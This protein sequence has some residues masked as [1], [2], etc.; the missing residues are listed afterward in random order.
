MKEMLG[1]K[2]MFPGLWLLPLLVFGVVLLAGCGG[3]GGGGAVGG[4]GITLV[5]IE[6]S[7]TNPSIALGTT[8]Q[9]TATGVYSDTT[10]QDLTA[11]VA[12]SSST[13]AATITA[14]GLATGA[15][16]G[17]A[18]ITAT[19]GSIVSNSATLTVTAGTLA[20]IEVSP[21]NPTIALGTTRQFRA[22]AIFSDTTK[23][24]ITASATW[25]SSTAAATIT[26]AG[27]ATGA[28]SGTASITASF[29][30]LSG[31]TTLTVTA[32]TLASIEVTPTNPTIA[33]GTTRQFTA[34][35][36]Y[37]DNTTQNLTRDVIWSSDNSGIAQIGN[38]EGSYGLAKSLATGTTTIKATSGS[39]QGS[40]SLTVTSA[41]LEA[42]DVTPAIPSIPA[43][44]KQ[45][46]LATGTFSDGTSKDMT[47]EVTWSSTNAGV[48]TVSNAAGTSG[49]ATT[50]TQ[51]TATITATFGNISGS[52]LLTVTPATI[53]DIEVDPSNLSIPR[54]STQQFTAAGILSD[55][56]VIDLTPEVT[57]S[58][59]A[60]EV[61][62]VSNETGFE[63]IAT[64]IAP[65]TATIT[66]VYQGVIGSATLT[67]T[68]ATLVSMAI[69]PVTSS[70]ALGTFQKYNA[71][72]TYSDSSTRDI[73]DS[74][75]WSSTSLSV[76]VISNAGGET[77][78][79]ATSV[80]VGSTTIKATSGSI[81]SNSATL[82]VTSATL[83][84]ITVTPS[85]TT[86]AR[87]STQQFTAT[88]I[89]SD[90]SEQV[91]TMAATWSSSA[92]TVAVISNAS[93]SQGLATGVGVG[94]AT[95][96][97]RFGGITGSTTLTVINATLQAI[98][99]TPINPS[100]PVNSSQ[101][102]TATGSFTGGVIQDITKSVKWTSSHKNT[103]SVSNGFNTRGLAKAVGAGTTTISATKSGINGG[104]SLTV[105]P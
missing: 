39:V 13:A 12:W 80:G 99:V 29:G 48:A 34:I 94:S 11:S 28:S 38:A 62:T 36:V 87:K 2:G 57:W 69:T 70:I 25:S 21:T 90:S 42:L 3:G 58:S 27:L 19:S 8:W 47:S 51:G 92:T 75:T 4:N 88:G 67:V 41:T 86:I 33:L 22:V 6:V 83:Q 15:S 54:G 37:T 44:L 71:I 61:V 18:S 84:S 74:V 73:S 100:I 104:T 102:F 32:A 68:P 98:V 82:T 43:G 76:A 52:T 63:G 9:F 97:A 1:K 93:N 23:Q 7:P 59:S 64:A 91:L 55:D 89:F 78:G 96:T 14:A 105:T 50:L 85:N 46:F 56:T 95:I 53:I 20:S 72:G 81:G 49:L 66:A 65:G 30:G 35:G 77:N 101:Q 103:A 16:S 10:R 24:D 40:A 17:T 26:A 79:L 31:V 60:T 5:A 45:Q